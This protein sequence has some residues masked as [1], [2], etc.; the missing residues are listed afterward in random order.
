MHADPLP[1]PDQPGSMLHPNDG[2]QAVL[3]GDHRAMRHQPPHLGH[4]ALD[5][6]E[7]GRPAGIRVGR[8]QDV[9]RLEAGLLHVQDDTGPPLDGPGGDR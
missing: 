8:D 1:I 7:Q 5:R 3:P 2:R 6:D 4:Q 9:A